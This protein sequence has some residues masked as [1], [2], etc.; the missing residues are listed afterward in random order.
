MHASESYVCGVLPAWNCSSGSASKP[1]RRNHFPFHEDLFNTT[2]EKTTW[3]V[4]RND[5]K[6]MK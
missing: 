6:L 1:W 5:G 4:R 2:E 3:T